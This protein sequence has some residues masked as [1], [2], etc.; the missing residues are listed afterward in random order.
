MKTF[1][2]LLC[3]SAAQSLGAQPQVRQCDKRSSVNLNGDSRQARHG[4][5]RSPRCGRPQRPFSC[6]GQGRPCPRV[7]PTICQLT[8]CAS[9]PL[10]RS[11][12]DSCPALPLPACETPLKP[13]PLMSSAPKN[14]RLFRVTTVSNAY[15]V[16]IYL[17]V[18][19]EK[20]SQA[21]RSL[22]S[23]QTCFVHL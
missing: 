20:Q 4:L 11:S 8:D 5:H 2:R 14:N 13:P 15:Q 9:A 6:P 3:S 12:S 16:Y 23:L 19:G 10:A 7:T 18:S 1:P 17:G 21:R 22:T